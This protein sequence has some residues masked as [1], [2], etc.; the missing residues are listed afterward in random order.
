MLHTELH[1]YK[2]K[3]IPKT[4]LIDLSKMFWSVIF[5]KYSI[6]ECGMIDCWIFW[7]S[8]YYFITVPVKF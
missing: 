3:H 5:E 2:K 7:N 6:I 4:L 1:E 8:N